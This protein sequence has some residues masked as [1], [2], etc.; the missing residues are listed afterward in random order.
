[1]VFTDFLQPLLAHDISIGPFFFECALLARSASTLVLH[2]G[3]EQHSNGVIVREHRIRHR[4]RRREGV[5]GKAVQIHRAPRALFVGTTTNES[6]GDLFRAFGD[7]N[8]F[9]EIAF[10]SANK[11]RQRENGR[12]EFARKPRGWVLGGENYGWM[13]AMELAEFVELDGID[14]CGDVFDDAR[15][16]P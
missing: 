7:S 13:Q 16:R 14:D 4:A 5:A 11:V 8:V 15:C 10:G 6:G 3:V 9:G 2:S 12:H 1:M